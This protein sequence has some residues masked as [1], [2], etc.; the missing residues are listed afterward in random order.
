MRKIILNEQT[1][2]DIKYYIQQGHTIMETSNKFTLKPD[3]LKRIMRENNIKPFFKKPNVSKRPITSEMIQGACNLYL[4]TNT[5]LQTIAKTFKLEYWELQEIL[6]SNFTEEEQKI[7]KRKLYSLSKTD[8]KN[9]MKDR[10]GLNHPNYKGI[11]DDGNGYLMCLKPDWYTGR[12]KSNYVFVHTLVMCE[13]LN[14]TEL[15]K[16]FVIHHIN[17]DKKDNNI[18]NLALLTMGAHTKLHSIQNNMCKVQRLFKY[19]VG[20]EGTS[21]S[22]TP[23]D[24]CI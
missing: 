20:L 1:I 4:N 22:E 13:A 9:P 3:T 12:I 2:Q 16:G 14:I 11:V 24:T 8:S 15:P 17:G 10:T 21:N 7:R 6:N 19:E 18:S 5:T 23:D